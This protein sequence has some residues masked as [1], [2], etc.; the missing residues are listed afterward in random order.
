MM[1]LCDYGHEEICYESRNCPVCEKIKEISDL[2]DKVFDL[3]E[4]MKELNEAEP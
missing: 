2:E 3:T 4:Q 1:H